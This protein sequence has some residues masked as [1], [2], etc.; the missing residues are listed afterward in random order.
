VFDPDSPP[1]F[2]QFDVIL[3]AII[4]YG[5]QGNPRSEA[6]QVI[7]LMNDSVKP[8]IALDAPSGLDT[9]QGI[10]GDPCIKAAATMTLALPKTGLM[11][12]D[13]QS[14]TGDL[15]LADISVPPSLYQHLGLE[16]PPLFSTDTIVR[17]PHGG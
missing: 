17:V 10:P 1:D 13:A 16:V 4:G 11:T 8:I 9:T 3:D 5:L 2:S 15:Y 12:A 14:V 6:A 7:R